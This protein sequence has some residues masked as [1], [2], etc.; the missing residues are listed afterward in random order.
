MVLRLLP[1]TLWVTACAGFVIWAVLRPVH[2]GK[3]VMPTAQVAALALCLVAAATLAL[4]WVWLGLRAVGRAM[5]WVQGRR[6]IDRRPVRVVLLALLVAAPLL[7][8][9]GRYVEPRWVAVRR[10]PLGSGQGQPVRVTV[11]S[12]LHIDGDH[13]PFR[14]LARRVNATRPDVVLLLGDTLNRPAGLSTLR[15]ELGRMRA[16]HGKLAV[17]GNWDTWYW[18]RLPLLRGTGFRWVHRQ[19]LTRRIRG[20]L[21]QIVG[22]SYR[23]GE[24][25]RDARR[26]LA[27]ADPRGWR[28]M[29]YHTPD[30]VLRTPAADLYL[31]GHTHGGQVALPLFGALVTLSVHGKRFERGLRGLP[32]DR[33]AP[34]PGRARYIYVNPGLGV[35]PIIPLRLGVRP[36]ITV[37]ELTPKPGKRAA[38]G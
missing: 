33:A 38:A 29:L 34:G 8:V 15:R 13:A 27:G 23:D 22:L 20:Q 12:D 37:F 3:M 19:R 5:G 6:L 14:G 1:A 24:S 16:S 18:S 32:G 9:Y 2:I 10:V 36:E 17:R 26:L 28:I 21:I 30:L 35:E 31:A 7:Y 11:I 25:G 4:C